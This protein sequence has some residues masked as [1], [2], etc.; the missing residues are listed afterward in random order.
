M[1]EAPQLE[2]S[3]TN[4]EGSLFSPKQYQEMEVLL[5]ELELQ[6]ET[7]ISAGDTH[8]DAV[9]AALDASLKLTDHQTDSEDAQILA[10]IQAE[11][12]L[13]PL[14]QESQLP[15]PGATID[16]ILAAMN[17]ARTAKQT[18]QSPSASRQPRPQSKPV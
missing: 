11:R 9:Q 12:K 1:T 13:D 17:Q 6:E 2:P 16:Q 18:P 3:Q 10:E 8:L 14:P 7:Q 4:P 5:T 15:P